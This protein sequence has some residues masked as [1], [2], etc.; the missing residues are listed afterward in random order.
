MSLGTAIWGVLLYG[1]L[2]VLL[3][4]LLRRAVAQ[5]MPANLFVYL[6]VA[7]FVTAGLVAVLT[8]LATGAVVVWSGAQP[9]A[10]M[11]GQY[12]PFMMLIGFAEATLTGMV[13]T[14]FVVYLP[15]WVA[16]FED[17]HYLQRRG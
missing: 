3:T 9:A 7:G 17:A 5:W 6:L 4:D 11:F 14:L 8:Q 12:M 10:T 2:P 15:G 16:T 13:L 1:T